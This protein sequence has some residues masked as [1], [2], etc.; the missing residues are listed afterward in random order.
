MLLFL[1]ACRNSLLLVEV[2]I[3]RI[4]TAVTKPQASLRLKAEVKT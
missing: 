2:K 1:N 3:V 4:S